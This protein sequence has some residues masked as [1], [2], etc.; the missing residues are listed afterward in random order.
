MP[1]AQDSRSASSTTD[2]SVACVSR[3]SASSS[4]DPAHLV[5]LV[6]RG[7][8]GL[9]PTGA[10]EE[11]VDR[12]VE[13]RACRGRRSSVMAQIGPSIS[14]A[15][16]G[17]LARLAAAAVSSRVSPASGVPL[18]SAQSGGLAPMGQCDLV[19]P[20][21]LR[22]TTPPADVARAFRRIGTPQPAT[23]G[24]RAEARA[25]ARC[26]GRGPTGGD[27]RWGSGSGWSGAQRGHARRRPARG[28]GPVIDRSVAGQARGAAGGAERAGRSR[29]RWMG[30]ET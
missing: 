9:P 21:M 30:W 7:P 3:P 12:L 18:G 24:G 13:A 25:A 4:R 29:S 16:P 20:S 23:R 6:R 14:T 19:R 2:R 27:R 22:W 17:L 26:G 5:E 28:A 15:Q 8:P 11:E 10:H 1:R